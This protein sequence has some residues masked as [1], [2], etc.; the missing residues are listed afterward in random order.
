MLPP[1]ISNDLKLLTLRGTKHLAL[2]IIS[3][4]KEAIAHFEF[5]RNVLVI[6]AFRAKV[7]LSGYRFILQ[8]SDN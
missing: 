2:I 8:Y 7:D 6:S 5:N 4:Y 3:L 1:L